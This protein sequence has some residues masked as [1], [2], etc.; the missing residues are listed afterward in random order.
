MAAL[1]EMKLAFDAEVDEAEFK[2]P[3]IGD[4]L[5]ATVA[6]FFLEL[7]EWER[8]NQVTQATPLSSS[9]LQSV[10]MESEEERRGSET[11]N[12]VAPHRGFCAGGA[13]HCKHGVDVRHDGAGRTG[14]L[15][16]KS[17]LQ[18]CDTLRF[19]IVTNSLAYSKTL[20]VL[21]YVACAVCFA[22][23]H[24]IRSSFG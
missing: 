10:A 18:S 9:R 14:P 19:D 20:L 16:M 4:A 2:M 12:Q 11:G 7:D 22:L 3:A 8:H 23:C 13:V 17:A 1:E 21:Y 5:T 6:G 24:S 15:L